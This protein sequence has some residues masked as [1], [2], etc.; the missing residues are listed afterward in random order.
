M[1][2]DSDQT[3]RKPRP[4]HGFS[5]TAPPGF[6]KLEGRSFIL[7]AADRI[8]EIARD[9]RRSLRGRDREKPGPRSAAR[10]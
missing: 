2:T 7:V 5:P 8:G 10:R 3:P 9:V 1:L 4:P 6:V